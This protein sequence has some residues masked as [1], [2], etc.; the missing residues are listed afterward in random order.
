MA[1]DS[2]EPDKHLDQFCAVNSHIFKFITATSN[3]LLEKFS[4]CVYMIYINFVK[5]QQEEV[6]LLKKIIN[7]VTHSKDLGKFQCNAS[8]AGEKEETLRKFIGKMVSGNAA[9]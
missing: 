1:R 8:A 3:F 9:F 2:D 5:D 6:N 7:E 4:P